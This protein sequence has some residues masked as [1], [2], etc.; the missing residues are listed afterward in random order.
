MTLGNPSKEMASFLLLLFKAL[1]A[2]LD[3]LDLL[4][5]EDLFESLIWLV[6]LP[7]VLVVRILLFLSNWGLNELL[8]LL[9]TELLIEYAIVD[10]ARV[11]LCFY[12]ESSFNLPQ[13]LVLFLPQI[14]SIFILHRLIF[15]ANSCTLIFTESTPF[16]HPIKSSSSELASIVSIKQNISHL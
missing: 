12:I 11:C 8:S 15:S 16:S 7:I 5:L 6:G 10:S 1:P 13:T 2:T 4:V 14:I 3:N 9:D